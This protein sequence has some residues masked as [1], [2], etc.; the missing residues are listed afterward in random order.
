MMKLSPED[1]NPLSINIGTKKGRKT[2]I[3]VP[4]ELKTPQKRGRKPKNGENTNEQKWRLY[5]TN[6]EPKLR[7]QM[8]TEEPNEITETIKEALKDINI[9]NSKNILDEAKQDTTDISN[10]IITPLHSTS[11]TTL[12]QKR[13]QYKDSL[14]QTEADIKRRGQLISTNASDIF[15]A[16]RHNAEDNRMSKDMAFNA[17]KDAVNRKNFLIEKKKKIEDMMGTQELRTMRNAF[18]KIQEFPNEVEKERQIEQMTKL[19][20]AYMKFVENKRNIQ[21]KKLLLATAEKNPYEVLQYE[22]QMSNRE[23][24]NSQKGNKKVGNIVDQI[25]QLNEQ[26]RNVR[27]FLTGN[28]NRERIE[29]PKNITSSSQFQFSDAQAHQL[30]NS[31]NR[32]RPPNSQPKLT[33]EERTMA[34]EQAQLE[35]RKRE[36]KTQT[37]MNKVTPKPSRQQLEQ[38]SLQTGASPFKLARQAQRLTYGIP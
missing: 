11:L 18:L 23:K 36:I 10:E 30:I 16:L 13:K 33:K 6:I 1:I 26:E 19:R 21:N 24:R 5:K 32:G 9:S 15:S 34:K 22:K 29:V 4:K 28:P 35:K 38:Q 31:P 17:F 25:E 20:D 37:V 14:K 8:K 27:E 3:K 7:E 12:A 2:N